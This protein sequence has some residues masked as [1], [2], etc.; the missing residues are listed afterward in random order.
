[1]GRIAEWVTAIKDY[2]NWDTNPK[3]SRTQVTAESTE[4]HLEAATKRVFS[5]AWIRQLGT[6]DHPDFFLASQRI[7]ELLE[8]EQSRQRK[9]SL[10]LDFM[11]AWERD[12]V[13]L[14]GFRFVRLEAKSAKGNL[15][16]VNDTFPNPY[17]DRDEIY[18]LF[19]AK[20]RQVVVSTSATMAAS[21][22]T[23]P[24]IASRYEESK[25]TTRQFGLDLRRIWEG[26][27][28]RTAARPTY[29]VP[30]KYAE[31]PATED[32]LKALF[33]QADLRD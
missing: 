33:A 32:V 12:Q 27:P 25:A 6:Q 23:S 21:W 7:G 9:D 10:T 2:Q 30:R 15:Y 11:V 29:R 18:V 4:S 24:S 14:P 3:A 31:V 20:V 8:A 13:D 26:T 22:V 16:T 28:V 19:S 5:D 1:M 17:P